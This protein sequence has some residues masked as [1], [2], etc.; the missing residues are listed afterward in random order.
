MES[1]PNLPEDEDWGGED[2][3]SDEAAAEW[4]NEIT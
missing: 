4:D 2:N 3:W 1:L